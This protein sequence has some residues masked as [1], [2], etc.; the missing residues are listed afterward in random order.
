MRTLNMTCL[1]VELLSQRIYSLD[2]LQGKTTR[3]RL[4]RKTR[5]THNRVSSHYL[6]IGGDVLCQLLHEQITSLIIEMN[7][8]CTDP[9]STKCSSRIFHSILQS[10]QR[11]SQFQFS[12]YD[13]VPDNDTLST[14]L[15]LVET[16]AQV[17]TLLID[18]VSS[19]V[20]L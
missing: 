16:S 14:F 20:F 7:D 2:L 4:P 5:T 6:P 1:R 17:E 9:L 18:F 8:S 12:S 13:H 11:L 10:C 15:L 3:V 19:H